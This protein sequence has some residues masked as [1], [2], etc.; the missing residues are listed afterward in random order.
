MAASDGEV[1]TLV[2]PMLQ[3]G[4]EVDEQPPLAVGAVV[5]QISP[6]PSQSWV[7]QEDGEQPII[8]SQPEEEE[9]EEEEKPNV[10]DDAVIVPMQPEDEQQV[11]A[12]ALSQL[13]ESD[14]LDDERVYANTPCCFRNLVCAKNDYPVCV[15]HTVPL[16]SKLLK[17]CHL[18]PCPSGSD[19]FCC[20]CSLRHHAA[21]AIRL[22]GNV[23]YPKK[24]VKLL[25]LISEDFRWG[26]HQDAHELLRCLLDKLDEYSVAPRLSS[27]EPSS[28]VKEVFGGQLKS[29]L[30][31]PECNHCSDRL[32]S[33]LDLS[34]E[35]NQMD[36][37]LDSLESF[38]KIEV[39]ES[40]ICDGC[41]SRVD[42]EKRLKVERAPEVLVIQLKRFE[43]LGSSI[44]KI[45]EMVK[46][47]LELD[48]SPFMSSADTDPQNYDLYGV[49]EHLGDS[50]KGHYVCYIRSSE[51]DWYL[52]NDDKVMKLSE[53]GVLDSK[54]YLLFYVKRG[55][56]P[57]F[58]TLLEEKNNFLLGYLEELA[59]KGLNEDGVPVDSDN[60]SNSG[61]G[62]GSGSDSD[63][64]DSV[65]DLFGGPAARD[66]ACPSPV[67]GN[68]NGGTNTPDENEASCCSSLGGGPSGETQK[69]T[70]PPPSSSAES[71]NV[72]GLA[73]LLEDKETVRPQGGQR[74]C[75]GSQGESPQENEGS[76]CSLLRSSP[77]KQEEGCCP[78]NLTS[79]ENKDDET[80]RED[81]EARGSRDSPA[82][83]I[84]GSR[85]E[86]GSG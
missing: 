58:S 34:L 7:Q 18:G 60:G 32:E 2:A 53:E 56:S 57:W 62:S 39:V 68:A 5:A 12:A 29:Q 76:C 59:E 15:V 69:P 28:I 25:K 83:E 41:K 70:S 17:D 10:A 86:Q 13:L 49:V 9:D 72:G 36:T 54:A 67:Q 16:V 52:F 65:D 55:S 63:E 38:T 78:G 85:P 64:Q 1:N 20:Y 40:F 80:K 66:E 21:E 81:D 82:V 31:C 71:G 14:S 22:S 48:L 77:H 11:T 61:S 79:Q 33:F 35:I 47:Q 6:P 3:P 23:L 4:E 37:V 30:H 8:S 42:M 51:T 24:F 19:E 50:S 74:N 73:L 75:S 26:G 46:Y 84:M 44:S 27:E 43:N 45:R